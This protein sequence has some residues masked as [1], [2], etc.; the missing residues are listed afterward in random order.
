[1]H[2]TLL[3]IE[4]LCQQN[5]FVKAEMLAW[6][7]YKEN[8][9]NFI[10]VKALGTCLV[11]QKKIQGSIDILQKAFELN[12]KDF[13]INNN[14]SYLYIEIL[15]AENAKYFGER[16]L[17]ILPDRPEPY[18][19]LARVFLTQRNYEKAEEHASKSIELRGGLIETA[20]KGY[21]DC[22]EFYLD[23][24]I[25]QEKLEDCVKICTE[26]LDEVHLFA[27]LITLIDLDVYK[28]KEAYL[29]R[30][31]SFINHTSAENKNDFL[32]TKAFC[33]F[34]MAKFFEKKKDQNKSERHYLD[35][36]IY[37]INWQRFQP[38]NRQK[39]LLKSI[40][41]FSTSK[42]D[43]NNIPKDKG[44]GLI[45]IIGMP[46]SG[47][48]LTE[49]ILATNTNLFAGGEM[50]YF[51][52]HL[53]DKIFEN[54]DMDNFQ[55]DE[56]FL[57]ELGDGYLQQAKFLKQNKTYFSDKLPD[58]YSYLGFIKL[59]LPGVKFIFISRDP[60]DNA[61][62]IFK[63]VYL[64]NLLYSSSFF[65]IGLEYANH[66]AILNFWKSYF[67]DDVF[68]SISYEQI[69]EDPMLISNKI[70]EYLGFSEKLDLSRRSMFY[71]RTAS[72]TQV[73]GGIHKDSLKKQEFL[74]QKSIF[75]EAVENQSYFWS[76]KL[77][78]QS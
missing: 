47:T 49:S 60:W 69:V 71:A 6:P 46:R 53:K 38:L 76:K 36:N 54:E 32:Q 14:L 67:G 40:E 5:N 77:T 78:L 59:A 35:A 39:K 73:K 24:L 10:C 28:V 26:V 43:F 2:D 44:E 16:A 19:N 45:F 20:K 1:M 22:F 63:Q 55:I 64:S 21:G 61:V 72:K 33:H 13:D 30:I 29:D 66:L 3:K 7:L 52:N 56:N 27:C 9:K 17:A 48:T 58:N 70:W 23:S 34:T 75:E 12:Q 51:E 74:D 62:S 25:A 11:A 41:L 4:E 65:N 31:R 42:K 68:L 37:V 18:L 8:P 15:D 57:I 50:L